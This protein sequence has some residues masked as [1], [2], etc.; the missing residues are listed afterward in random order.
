LKIEKVLKERERAS[1]INPEKALE[2]KSLG[3]EKY[4]KGI[5]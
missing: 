5:Q 1:Y 4:S 3:N 2:E